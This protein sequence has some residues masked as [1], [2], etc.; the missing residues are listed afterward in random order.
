MLSTDLAA[1]DN[2]EPRALVQA[3]KRNAEG[4]PVDFMFQLTDWEC[5]RARPY[6]FTGQGAAM[7][8]SVL[9]SARAS[10]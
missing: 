5:A 7:L 1:L 4:F 3:V 9:R 2:V 8:S 6:A 10:A